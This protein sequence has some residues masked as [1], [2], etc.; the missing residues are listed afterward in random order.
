LSFVGIKMLIVDVYKIPTG[1]SL[2]VIVMV[3]ALSVI[4][5]L[6]WPPKND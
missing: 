3:L 2:A 4:A 5:S 1:V 6:L